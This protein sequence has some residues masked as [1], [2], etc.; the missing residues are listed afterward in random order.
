MSLLKSAECG[1]RPLDSAPFCRLNFTAQSIW[2]ISE[3]Y[4]FIDKRA[5]NDTRGLLLLKKKYVLAILTN[6]FQKSLTSP[7]VD[8]IG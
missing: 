8:Q 5:K 6:G 7:T 2:N 3:Y 4:F 1:L